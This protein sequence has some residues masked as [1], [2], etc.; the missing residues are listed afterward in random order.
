MGREIM[1][2]AED[3]GRLALLSPFLARVLS[4]GPRFENPILQTSMHTYAPRV[5]GAPM[6]CKKEKVWVS[7]IL[8]TMMNNLGA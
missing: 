3:A 7:V 5:R 4:Q 6:Q 8:L 1:E 2:I